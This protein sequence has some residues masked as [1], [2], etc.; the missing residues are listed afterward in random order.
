MVNICE[1]LVMHAVNLYIDETQ[2]QDSFQSLKKELMMDAHVENVAFSTKMPHDM[3]VEYDEKFVS[4]N[5]IVDQ[6]ES[7]GLHVDITGG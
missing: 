4:P 2:S 3:L 5:S 6:L 1:D 7:H